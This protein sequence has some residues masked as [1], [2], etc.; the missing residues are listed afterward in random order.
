MG[1]V[2]E[3]ILISIMFAYKRKVLYVCIQ[4]KSFVCLQLNNAL[5]K[6]NPPN[7][8]LWLNKAQVVQ[9]QP[10]FVVK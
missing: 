10:I 6:F 1:F 4:K 8:E 3:N 2:I 9:H 7:H 5:I